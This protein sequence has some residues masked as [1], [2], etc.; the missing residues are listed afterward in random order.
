MTKIINSKRSGPNY[1]YS[2]CI[3]NKVL[4]EFVTNRIFFKSPNIV[5]KQKEL[6]N[7]SAFVATTAEFEYMAFGVGMAGSEHM[8][9][10]YSLGTCSGLTRYLLGTR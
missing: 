5:L 4:V 2:I 9:V 7:L 10:R 6:I 1:A 3:S 8:L